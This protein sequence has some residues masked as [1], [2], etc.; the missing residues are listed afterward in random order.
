MNP[1]PQRLEGIVSAVQTAAS[2]S[3]SAAARVLGL[4]PAAVSKNVAALEGTLGVRLFNRSTRSLA[5]TEEG[6]RFVEQARKG[7]DALQAAADGLRSRQAAPQGL[8]RVSVGAGFGR[9]HVLP[10]L[11]A[12][13]ARY[14][15]V[16]VELNL[17]DRTVDLLREGFDIGIRGGAAPPPG[18]VARRICDI[19]MVL[20]ASPAYLQAH[21]MP[22]RVD[23]LARH[24]AIGARFQSG[25]YGHWEFGQGRQRLS[26]VPPA[27]LW[28]SDPEAVFEAALMG[29]GI[30]QVGLY[31]A[32]AH[33][34]RGEL[35][36]LLQGVHAPGE[37]T[38]AMFYPHRAGLA[39]RVRVLADF[40]LERMARDA[41]LH[42][43]PADVR[44][45]AQRAAP[46]SRRRAS[47]AS[48]KRSS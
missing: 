32:W 7:L 1:S 6:R 37:R 3:F 45:L 4:T 9:R 27:R 23:D 46:A 39:P 20:V 15:Q 17:A 35:V 36:A 34:Q 38:M 33:L 10:H 31:H 19:P 48:T 24:V 18:M 25:Q 21:G 5:L 11:P 43:T 40:L 44:A 14:P 28:L 2:G 47:K 22:Q 13:A 30:A 29:A 8:V 26:F 16:T 41:A 12:F 42:V